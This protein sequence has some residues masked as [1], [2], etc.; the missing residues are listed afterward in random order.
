M[1]EYLPSIPKTWAHPLQKKKKKKTEEKAQK[2]SEPVY[3]NKEGGY[4]EQALW[5]RRRGCW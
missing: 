4:S 1:V 5:M 2:Q 3:R